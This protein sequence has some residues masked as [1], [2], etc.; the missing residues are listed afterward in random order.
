ML[1]QDGQKQLVGRWAAEQVQ[2]GMV[3]GL[4]TGSTAVW[5]V[6]ALAERVRAGL[7]CTGVCTSLSTEALARSLGIAVAALD[8][9]PALD[10]AIDGADEVDPALDL[11]KGLGGA[12]LRE[13]LV[14]Q[15]AARFLVIVDAS[16][17]VERLGVRAPLPVEVV[18]F[19]WRR[20]QGALRALGCT[21]ALRLANGEPFL[22]DSQHYIVDCRFAGI[23]DAA[24]LG[25]QIKLLPG[26]V[27]HG[28]FV[29]MAT[30]VAVG[31]ADGTVAVRQRD[32]EQ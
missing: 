22:T 9:Q 11:I 14:E 26:V 15:A 8:D 18:P 24:A 12:L 21:P 30:A 32:M 2:D 31:Q 6:R 17:L 3:V 20:T 7:R 19:G 13:K 16:K 27:D 10:L 25:R 4:G 1:D 23:A 28:L 29:G 5:A